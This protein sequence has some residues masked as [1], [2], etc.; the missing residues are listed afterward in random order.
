MSKKQPDLF[1]T[2]PPDTPE[3]EKPVLDP[4]EAKR[5]TDI[6]I[7]RS[8]AAATEEW[9]AEMR[10][11]LE[12]VAR[13]QAL[14][15]SDDLW[16]LAG[17]EKMQQCNRSALGG[18]FTSAAKAGIMRLTGVWRVSERPAHHRKLLRVWES[19]VCLSR[20]SGE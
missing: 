3:P 13:R 17:T 2:D 12:E 8:E 16:A 18:I 14:F 5:L 1:S 20:A 15:T 10:L 19:N 6:G 11:C 7:A 9:K 4:V